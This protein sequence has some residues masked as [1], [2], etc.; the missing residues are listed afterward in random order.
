MTR[1]FR[2]KP[3]LADTRR[4]NK[5]AHE[6]YAAISGKETPPEQAVLHA[7]VRD[8]V[9]RP[10]KPRTDTDPL[11]ESQVQKN[12]I[13][14]LMKHER[15]QY[16]LRTNSGSA[17]DS[18]VQFNALYLPHR[19]RVPWPGVTPDMRISDLHVILI[20]A[21]LMAVECK[22]GDWKRSYGIS[23][24]A[25]REQAQENYLAHVRACGGIG[26]FATCVE[27]VGAVL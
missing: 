4:A 27:D 14:M 18:Y 19:F 9:S 5:A 12:I 20:D 13:N 15:V 21:S 22:P 2:F 8:K 11:P 7:D 17:G 24:K 10:R 1:P 23:D 16:V 26:I 6:Y 3:S 25:M